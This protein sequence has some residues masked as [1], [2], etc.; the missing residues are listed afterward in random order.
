MDKREEGT[1]EKM[2]YWTYYTR[3]DGYV[4]EKFLDKDFDTIETTGLGNFDGLFAFL[5]ET[6]FFLYLILGLTAGKG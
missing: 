2:R 6:E 4:K 3:D 1:E 5:L